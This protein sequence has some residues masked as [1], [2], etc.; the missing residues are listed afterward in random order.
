[1]IFLATASGLMMERVRSTAILALRPN[2]CE[3]THNYTMSGVPARGARAP[4][5]RRAGQG[6]KSKSGPTPPLVATPGRAPSR[7]M[8]RTRQHA[9]DKTDHIR[10]PRRGSDPGEQYADRVRAHVC[11]FKSTIVGQALRELQR[12]P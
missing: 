1:M 7:A 11:D 4:K 9:L 6:S 5:T 3:K 8:L 2:K 12:D 10:S